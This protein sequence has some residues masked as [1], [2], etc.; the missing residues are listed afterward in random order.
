MKKKDTNMPKWNLGLLYS[1]PLDPRIEKDVREVETLC[2]DFAKKYDVP[3]KAYLEDDDALLSAL[4]DFEAIIARSNTK[5]YLYFYFLKDI[6][7]SNVFASSQLPLLQ[8]RISKCDNEVT[9]FKISLGSIPGNK[10]RQFL[11][12][13]K[14]A[15]FKIFLERVFAD[16]EYM[17]SVPEEKIMNLK[18]QPS[19][20][21]WVHGN[22][23]ILNMKPVIWKKKKIPLAQAASIISRSM[24]SD[25][26]RKVS[27][28]TTE[29][30]KT[31]APF[32]EVEINAVITNKKIDD[33]LRGFSAAY[34]STVHEYRNDPEVVRK[35]VAT[36]TNSFGV[37]HRFFRVKAR[38]MK[39]KRFNYCDRMAKIGT[40][41]T[42]FTF[43]RSL[44]MLKETFGDISP[45]F[46]TFLEEYASKGQLDVP[47]RVGKRSG[48][49]CAGSFNNPTFVL[50]NHTD[51]FHSYTTFAHEMGHAFH[52]ELSRSQGPLY[53]D[54]STS[55]AETAS[56]LFE[57]LAREKVF[58]DLPQK[59]RIIALHDKI[60]DDIATV[61]RQIACFNYEDD[62]HRTIRGKGFMSKEELAES[63][64]KHMS[65]Y[66]GPLFKLTPDDG[67]FFVQW[68]H[69]RRFF[70]VY[71]YA[72]G[73]LVSKALLRRY[74]ADPAFWT[75]IET[76][77][78]AGGKDSPEKIL[79]EIGID[80]ESSGFFEEGIAEI[81]DD[82]KRL[83]EM[84]SL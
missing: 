84:A 83:E 29:M 18:A 75:K 73:M 19:Y 26:R 62:I 12:N 77:L 49:Y 57:S 40:V 81:N 33:E 17:L 52:G 1:S 63:H 44:S 6:D 54:Y 39:E 9:F 69:I 53:C 71:T 78:S 56:T 11:S 67:Y 24:N 38:I 48:A 51:D 74:R 30:L 15:H 21:M 22:E 32:S 23:K 27:D 58:S 55:L 37:V 79:K 43:E 14:L 45:K 28:A 64:N 16:A 65:A 68:S 13:P 35:L 31:V 72:Y 80:V 7:A 8:N 59:E 4:T 20:E 61:F 2:H 47:P 76:F 25:E 36:V 42:K 5:P 10:Q 3:I 34:E 46:E 60:N 66:L 82:V 50:L 70:Y 41:K